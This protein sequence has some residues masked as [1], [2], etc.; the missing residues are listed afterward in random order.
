MA[1][2]FELDHEENSDMITITRKD[3]EYLQTEFSDVKLDS[4]DL[5]FKKS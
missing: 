3:F 4:I 1:N 2:L 5:K